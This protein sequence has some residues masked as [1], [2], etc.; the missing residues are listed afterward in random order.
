M[1]VWLGV[2]ECI[3]FCIIITIHVVQTLVITLASCCVFLYKGT[4]L[5]HY[6]TKS[7]VVGLRK[8]ALRERGDGISLIMSL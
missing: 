5:C 3:K 4:L 8:N 7:R 2:V 6:Q 1:S